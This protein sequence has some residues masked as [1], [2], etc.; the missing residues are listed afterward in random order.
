MMTVVKFPG[1]EAWTRGL[2]K[3]ENGALRHKSTGN[4]FLLLENMDLKECFRLNEFTK[5]VEIAH[6]V[7]WSKKCGRPIQ[8]SDLI[9]IVRW[10][11][12]VGQFGINLQMCMSVVQ[13][14]A[15]Q[16]SY[17]PLQ[18]W[19]LSLKWDGQP[20]IDKWISY[21]LGCE[22]D[23]YLEAIGAKFLIG[24]VARVSDPGCKFDNMLILEGPQG[25]LKSS[26]L[27]VLFGRDYFTDEIAD[28]GSK[29][30]AMQL[31]GVWCVEIAELST[32]TRS[33]AERI[34]EFVSRRVDRLRPP[35]GRILVKWPRTA[36]LVGTTN[37]S[38]G[39]FQDHTGNRR[40]WPVTCVKIALDDL[41]KAREQLWAEAVSRYLTSDKWW[42]EGQ[43]I[44]LASVE[45]NARYDEDAWHGLIADF[46]S[47]RSSIT[48]HEILVTCLSIPIPQ[49]SDG[50]KKRVARTLSSLGWAPIVTKGVDR[51]SFRIW[52]LKTKEP[53]HDLLEP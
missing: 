50:S 51:K 29:D 31:Q 4:C 1:D 46:V 18:A 48:T 16:H 19:L 41:R 45:Q 12:G 3:S 15:E 23:P 25:I 30:A 6:P 21:Y 34:K 35:Y 17:H 42:L 13:A 52:K 10:L 44:E 20:R 8:E 22:A 28:F 2:H 36:V 26:C 14:V 53:Q 27:E 24:C 7:P 11:E 49:I 37:A 40:F 5:E 47:G 43:E 32:F 33:A 38:A 9:E 39:Y